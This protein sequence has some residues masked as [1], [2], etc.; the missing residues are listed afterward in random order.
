MIKERLA[1]LKRSALVGMPGLPV[2]AGVVPMSEVRLLTLGCVA[3]ALAA[4][5]VPR[6]RRLGHSRRWSANTSASGRGRRSSAPGG[7]RGPASFPPSPQQGGQPADAPRIELLGR[8]PLGYRHRPDELASPPD[9]PGR[10]P[11]GEAGLEALK[12]DLF[13]PPNNHPRSLG[14]LILGSE[15]RNTIAEPPM[16]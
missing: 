12:A 11:L 4:A 2:D 6:C 9:R 10:A 1:L 3:V 14:H 5:T 13:T 8:L 16:R 15:G 7:D